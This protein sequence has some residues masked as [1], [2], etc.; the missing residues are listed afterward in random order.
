[1]PRRRTDFAAV[2]E[3]L[4]RHRVRFL[5]VGGVAAVVE[6]APVSTFDL[7]IVPERSSRNVERLLAALQDLEAFY[8]SRPDRR[9][10][11]TAEALA[12]DGHRLL[13]TRYGPL[14]VLAVIGNKRDFAALS[15]HTRRRTLG[16][17]NV[18]V[19]DLETQIDV[20]EELGQR[21]DQLMLPVLREALRLQQCNAKHK[22]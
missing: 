11:P 21:K 18:Q 22:K 6:G 12:G 10:R 19:L 14:D 1:V 4:R 9:L 20:Q 13:M 5:L 16:S 15:S 8:R 7:D 3:T 2:L 17:V